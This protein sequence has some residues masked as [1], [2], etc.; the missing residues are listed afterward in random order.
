MD[1][2]SYKWRQLKLDDDKK[3]ITEY[4][5]FEGEFDGKQCNDGKVFK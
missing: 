4:L 3:M 1:A 5:M 2:P